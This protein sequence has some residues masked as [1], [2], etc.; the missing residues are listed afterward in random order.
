MSRHED[1]SARGE[2]E[3]P[4][5][6]VRDGDAM[7]ASPAA[8]PPAEKALV[9]HER[10]CREYGCPIAYFHELDPL[11]ELV[12]SL[13]SHRTRNADSGRAFRALRARYPDW[14]AVRDAPTPEVEAAIAGVT[15]PEQKAP[16]IQAI[17]RTIGERVGQLGADALDFLGA[18]PADEARA[19]LE[20]LPGVGPKTSAAVLSFSRLRG[21]AL[22]VDSHHHRVAVRLGL[23]PESVAVGP[24][25]ARLAALLPA[26]WDAQTVYDHHEVL[27]LHGQRVCFWREPACTRCVVLDLCPTGQARLGE[28]ATAR[29]VRPGGAPPR[30]SRGAPPRREPQEQHR[31]SDSNNA[32]N[33]A[34]VERELDR[35]NREAR[36]QDARSAHPKA[37]GDVNDREH[38]RDGHA[39]RAHG[40]HGK[41]FTDERMID[42]EQATDTGDD[43]QLRTAGGGGDDAPDPQRFR[44][45][46]AGRS[47]GAGWGSEQVGGSVVDRRPPDDRKA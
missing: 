30:T 22:P 47:G 43:P 18:L 19:W 46:S 10:L 23:I 27:M 2:R 7:A 17:L 1:A 11:S 16:R 38:Y 31:M 39:E 42:D 21:V 32:S 26:D 9:A 15:W 44:D 41:G 25:H 34:D 37:S 6:V 29:G 3:V 33:R 8:L 4:A 14:A 20:A 24:S 13:L 28:R 45:N 40:T 12:S 35:M 5:V 36:E